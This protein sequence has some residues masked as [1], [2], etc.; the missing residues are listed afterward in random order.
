MHFFPDTSEADAA[1]ESFRAENFKGVIRD[2]FRQH[3][4]AVLDGGKLKHVYQQRYSPEYS[5]LDEFVNRIADMVTV[6][7]ENGTDAAFDDIYTA[8]LTES[9]LPELR[10]YAVQL[11]PGA[12][13]ASMRRKIHRA[14]VDEYRQDT[15]YRYAY[16]AG[17]QQS[18]ST[19]PRF[20]DRVARLVVNGAVMGADDT[21][22]KVYRSFITR[23][24]F[25]PSRRNPRRLKTW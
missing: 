5:S 2:D 1:A 13:P 22:G 16:K 14:V 11:L 3:I 9:P 6:G 19:F 24:P 18:F 25:P 23:C 12:F 20:I 10:R 4:G 7:A 8:F 15:V 21:L 17:Y